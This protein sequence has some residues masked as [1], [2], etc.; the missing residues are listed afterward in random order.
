VTISFDFP[1]WEPSDFDER[2]LIFLYRMPPSKGS[3]ESYLH[4][5][6]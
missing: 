4:K 3:L 1:D 6:G 2:D 5:Q